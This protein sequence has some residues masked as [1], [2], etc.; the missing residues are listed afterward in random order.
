MHFCGNCGT[1]LA[2]VRTTEERKVVTVL[3]VDVV[4]STRL[5]GVIDPEHLREKMS[6]V[7]A[8]AR[9]EIERRGGTVEKYIGDSV[10]AIF[11]LPT[12]HEDDPQRAAQAAAA[13]RS[14]V[15]P[16]TGRLPAL[17]FGIDTGEVVANPAAVEK[18][19]FLVTGE[20]VNLTARLQQ[21][22]GPGQ[23]LVG[24]RT[25]LGLR[26]VATLSP[27]PSL[28]VKGART[29]VPVWELVDVAPLLERKVQPTPF[30]GR[31][32]ELDLLTGLLRRMRRE[33]RG[34]VITILGPAGTG[35]TRLVLEF[36]NRS[37]TL[38]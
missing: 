13:I 34:H 22:A 14:R 29:P 35:K 30:V 4:E 24:E 7:F 3:F 33:S 12:V 15:Q 36:R 37:S 21:H 31:G 5:A 16:H 32:E 2:Q 38:R 8:I 19:E 27:L 1:P 20:V 6:S 26:R 28:Q 11:G 9:E 25:A 18:G 10:M 17:R 23:I